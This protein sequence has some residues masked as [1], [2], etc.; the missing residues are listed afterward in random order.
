MQKPKYVLQIADAFSFLNK[1]PKESIDLVITDPPYESLIKER[2]IGTTTRLKLW[3]PTISNE[4]FPELFWKIYR[5]LKEN[6]HF[7]C[8]CDSRTMFLLRSIGEEAGFK[9]WKPLVWNKVSMGMGYHYRSQVEYILFFEKGERQLSNFNVPDL[10]ESKRIVNAYPTQKP[11]DI[12]ST[13]VRQSSFEN[14]VICDPFFGSGSTC[15]AAVRN[16]C[17]FVGCDISKDA[18]DLSIKR[19]SKERATLEIDLSQVV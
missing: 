9:F 17:S 2:S 11:V 13:L 6:S 3:F 19:L 14:D 12:I 15:I 10:L 18:F 8:F 1:L 16:K 4:L 7:Y 5:V